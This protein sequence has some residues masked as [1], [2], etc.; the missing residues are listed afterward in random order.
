MT[1]DMAKKAPP[2]SPPEAGGSA[3]KE[4]KRGGDAGFAEE[5][6]NKTL[7]TP[8]AVAEPSAELQG[9]KTKYIPKTPYTRG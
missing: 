8:R 5:G 2:V 7:P 3:A 9:T 6:S 4:H 1:R